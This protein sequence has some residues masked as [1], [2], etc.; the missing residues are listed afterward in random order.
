[1]LSENHPLAGDLLSGV[2]A[3]S[4]HMYGDDSAS[5]QRR[6]RHLIS[7]GVIPSKKVAGRVES[8]RSWIDA[9]YSQ[10]DRPASSNGGVK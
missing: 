7:T 9:Y 3:I 5:N 6:V 1:M 4:R 8:R 2:A 10:P